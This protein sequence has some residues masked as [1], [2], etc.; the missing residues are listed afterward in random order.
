MTEIG[1]GISNPYNGE[2]RAGAVGQPLPGVQ[3]QLFDENDNVVE[4]IQ[5]QERFELKAIM[6]FLSIG[7]M[8]RPQKA[9]SKTAGFVLVTLRLSSK[10]TIALWVGLQSI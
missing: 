8:K 9:L 5:N 6:F 10:G 1:M 2:R 4:E 7:K 3:C